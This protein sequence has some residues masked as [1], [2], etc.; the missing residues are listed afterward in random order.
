MQA[1][2]K[3]ALDKCFAVLG[4]VRD[5]FRAVWTEADLNVR[6]IFCLV[7][8]VPSHHSNRDWHQITEE[9]RTQI[10]LRVKAMNDL[11]N[12]KLR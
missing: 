11:L 10:T 4:T 12:R 5:P 7:A 2:A 8:G 1:H 6:K 9:H 3:Q